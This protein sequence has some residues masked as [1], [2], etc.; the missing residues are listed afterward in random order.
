MPASVFSHAKGGLLVSWAHSCGHLSNP[1]PYEATEK[2]EAVRA[3]WEGRVCW[4]CRQ[5]QQGWHKAVLR[6]RNVV[7]EEA[8]S[9]LPAPPA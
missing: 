9:A 2:S 4:P 1:I 8:P 3:A 7:R 6:W 5:P